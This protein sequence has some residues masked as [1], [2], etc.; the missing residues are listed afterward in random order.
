MIESESKCQYITGLTWSQ[1]Y[2]SLKQSTTCVVRVWLQSAIS[3]GCGDL[4]VYGLLVESL[5]VTWT[6]KDTLFA[7]VLE[8]YED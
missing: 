4:R 2:L 3:S 5:E 6:L 1:P 7:R 8:L